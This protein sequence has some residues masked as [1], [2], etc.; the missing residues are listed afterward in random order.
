VAG[1]LIDAVGLNKHYRTGAST[2]QAV[3]DVSFTI[4]AGEFVTIVGRSGSGKS[5][6]MSL[7]GLLEQPD[8]GHYLLDGQDLASLGDDARAQRR[9][10]TV[11]FV[12]QLPS[13]LARASALDNVE[14]PLAYAGLGLGRSER[15]ARASD[16]LARV[17][18]AHR[19]DHWPNQLSGGE[20]QR[21]AIARA[22]INDPAVILADEP[23]GA[24]DTKTAEEI[25]ALFEALNAEGRTLVIVTHD[26][27]VAARA[28][29][30][31]HLNDGRIVADTRARAPRVPSNDLV[32]AAS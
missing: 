2:V 25:L 8:S 16:A 14:M 20:Q 3:R 18:L 21:V 5:T 29:R 31:I 22:L 19:M 4:E 11:G 7:L 23:T 1:A 10:R 30:E 12:F 32:S 27:D 17:G 13:L 15:R 24:L 6:L 28:G 9:C 26:P